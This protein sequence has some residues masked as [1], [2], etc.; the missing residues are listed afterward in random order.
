MK[1]KHLIDVARDEGVEPEAILRQA[2]C[3]ERLVGVLVFDASSWINWETF[4]GNDEVIDRVH[5]L[6]VV[7][8]DPRSMA[9]LISGHG[10]NVGLYGELPAVV[11]NGKVLREAESKNHKFIV[12]GYDHL[13]VKLSDPEE[14]SVDNGPKPKYS[15]EVHAAAL[16][17]V[18]ELLRDAVE[19]LDNHDL[20]GDF[21]KPLMGN[22]MRIT[23]SG[24][25]D[26]V[27]RR[28]GVSSGTL[29]NLFSKMKRLQKK[30]G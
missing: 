17:G 11:R 9:N 30:S 29:Q 14:G 15:Q 5:G 26:E 20:Y 7:G 6:P 8:V 21:T 2:M 22:S 13:L 24:V 28:T 10:I 3:G 1:W 18:F 4:P 23:Q 27:A 19:K 25:F 16:V 12:D